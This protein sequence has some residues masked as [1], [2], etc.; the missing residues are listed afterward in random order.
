MTTK[1]ATPKTKNAVKAGTKGAA[2]R[3]K[4]TTPLGNTRAID[5]N[6]FVAPK[7]KP[8][9]AAEVVSFQ[10]ALEEAGQTIEDLQVP[11]E[12]DRPTRPAGS[13]NLATT[14]RAHRGQYHVALAPNGKKTQNCGDFVAAALLQTTLADM[15]AFVQS[16]MAGLNYDHLNPGHQRMCYG[17][18]IR[19]WAKQ[20]EEGA[21][22]WLASLGGTPVEDDED[23]AQGE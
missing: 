1:N 6:S 20:N 12:A 8:K 22:N 7:R 17:N 14:I 16:R 15:K 10:Q 9:P 11:P 2:A 5:D 18:R 13:S 3:K 23:M 4:N 21:M 19:A